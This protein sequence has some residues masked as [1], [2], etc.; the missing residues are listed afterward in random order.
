MKRHESL[1]LW[2]CSLCLL[3]IVIVAYADSEGQIKDA[4]SQ[5]HAYDAAY[6]QVVDTYEFPGF[7][8]V[9]FNL[10]V[11]S[12]YSYALVSGKDALIVDPGRDVYA[13]L[14]LAEQDDLT[15]R[16]VYSELFQAILGHG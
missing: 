9:Q 14:D 5:T 2:L 16:H 10:P 13:Y 15:I 6:Y 12:H 11:L 3:S 8:V 4:E 7:K 1:L